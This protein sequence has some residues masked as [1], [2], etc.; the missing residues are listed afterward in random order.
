MSNEY[1]LCR[2]NDLNNR[3]T[4]MSRVNMQLEA[5]VY[6][7]DQSRMRAQQLSDGVK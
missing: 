4:E 5:G 1:P 7:L 3:M 6:D 2:I